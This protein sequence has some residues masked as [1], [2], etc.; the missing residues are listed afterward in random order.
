MAFTLD[1]QALIVTPA[2]SGWGPISPQ[3]SSGSWVRGSQSRS[4]SGLG[5][6][7]SLSAQLKPQWD[8]QKEELKG[9][10]LN[11]MPPASPSGF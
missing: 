5:L 1:K 3:R 9:S 8:N 11:S 4:R 7:A 2:G 10:S 6:S